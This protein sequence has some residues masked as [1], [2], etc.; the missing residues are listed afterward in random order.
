MCWAPSFRALSGRLKFTVQRHEFDG[1]FLSLG[2]ISLSVLYLEQGST[3]TCIILNVSK[4]KINLKLKL[5]HL[6]LFEDIRH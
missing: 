2:K 1:D 6:L 5:N 4:D 3:L